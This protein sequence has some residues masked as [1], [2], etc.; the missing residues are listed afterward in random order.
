M[1]IKIGTKIEKLHPTDTYK[2]LAW[3][4]I[5]DTHNLKDNID[6]L[7]SGQAILENNINMKLSGI[8][9]EDTDNN[10]FDDITGITFD[11]AEVK[12]D[13]GTGLATVVVKPKITVANGQEPD[14]TSLEGN[15]LILEGYTLSADPND[16]NVIRVGRQD[17]PSFDPSMF[18]SAVDHGYAADD[19][20]IKSN[21]T[22]D[23]WWIFKD[24]KQ[25]SGRP[26]D[27]SGDL[28]VFKN[29]IPNQNIAL[30][31]VFVMAMGKNKQLEN[32]VWFMYR[33]GTDWTPW[34]SEQGASQATIDN[35]SNSVDELKRANQATLDELGKL[36]TA[37]GKIYSP[38]DKAAFDTA[39]NALIAEALKNYVPKSGGHSSDKPD[40]VYP[41]FYAQFLNTWPTD[42][43]NAATSTN[44]E[45]TLLRIPDTPS[46][47]FITVENDNDEASKVKGFKFNSKQEMSLN[48]RDITIGGKKY[49][50]FYTAGAFTEKSVEIEVDFG[51][52][53]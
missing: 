1:S 38:G 14:S 45:V 31:H 41:R 32:K 8:H 50:A 30:K 29:E 47:I 33:D 37:I 39:V 13:Q 28:I 23:G 6:N 21:K 25:V 42:F 52:G 40:T 15:A 34:F 12:D 49:R 16:T 27:S 18:Q 43:T 44:S 24:L 26:A 5:E 2:L 46:R 10:A 36:Q 7:K 22:T 20:G 17:K 35:L 19:Q 48:F 53:I 9:L 3:D 4:D 11:G 51:Q